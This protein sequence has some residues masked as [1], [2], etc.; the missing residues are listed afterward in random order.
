MSPLL[1]RC[2]ATPALGTGHAMR[3]LALAQEWMARGG[4][5]VFAMAAPEPALVERLRAGGAEVVLL[6]SRA[7]SPADAVSTAALVCRIG[8]AWTVVDG[9][10][11]AEEWERSWPAGASLLRIDDNGLSRA[12]RADLL[13][14]QNV[15]TTPAD[16]PRCGERTRLLLGPAFVLLRPEFRAQGR[17]ARGGRL[18]VTMGGTDPAC[19][20]ERALGALLEPSAREIEADFVIGA[21]NPRRA[22][23]LQQVEAHAPRL[24]ALVAPPNLPEVFAR[25]EVALTA[26]G[27]TLYELAYLGTPMLVLATAENQRRTCEQFAACGAADYLGWHADL[28]PADLARMLAAAGSGIRRGAAAVTPLVDGGGAARVVDAMRGGGR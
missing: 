24:R 21:A 18:V 10:D 2:E 5:A 16:Y 9:P 28:P 20:T 15:G 17:L 1:L 22:A 11:L 19:A 4:R 23:L 8:A 6:D 12:F 3:G 7:G 26:G 14:N 25:A 27:S 13:L